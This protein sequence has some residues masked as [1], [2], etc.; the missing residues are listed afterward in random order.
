MKNLYKDTVYVPQSST[1]K[2]PRRGCGPRKKISYWIVW[3]TSKK[4]ALSRE[5]AT[6]DQMFNI[7]EEAQAECDKLNSVSSIMRS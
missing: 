5:L 2:T 4:Y 1:R 6:E 7:Y 3:V